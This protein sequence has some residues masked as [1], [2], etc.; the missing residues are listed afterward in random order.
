MLLILLVLLKTNCK[1]QQNKTPTF[2]HKVKAHKDIEGN[3]RAH[4]VAK[5]GAD[6]QKVDMT[7]LQHNAHNT[8]YWL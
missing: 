8:P 4:V 7:E 3:E 2:L 5:H 1:P 6:R